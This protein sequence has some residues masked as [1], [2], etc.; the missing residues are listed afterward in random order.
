MKQGDIVRI[1]LTGDYAMVLGVESKSTSSISTSSSYDD[2]KKLFTCRLPNLKIED[3]YSFE[4]S[5][6]KNSQQAN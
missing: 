3:F 5:E 1:K 6:T 4:L 2:C